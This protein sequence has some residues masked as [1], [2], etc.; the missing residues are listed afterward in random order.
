MVLELIK[1]YNFSI[2]YI[3]SHENG[4]GFQPFRM[5]IFVDDENNY[6]DFFKEAQRPVSSQCHRI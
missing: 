1:K 2:S 6:S 4:L 3:S 5:G